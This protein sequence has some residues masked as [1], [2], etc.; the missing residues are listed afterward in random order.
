MSRL[1]LLTVAQHKNLCRVSE[2]LL[3]SSSGRQMTP[4]HS[5][6]PTLPVLLPAIGI[7]LL[8]IL[9][10]EWRTER[11]K[12]HFHHHHHHHLFPGRLLLL[13]DLAGSLSLQF[14]PLRCLLGLT[15][16]TILFQLLPFFLCLASLF[17][18]P[19]L[20]FFLK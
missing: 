5:T 3:P 13:I 12:C 18:S 8:L 4:E 1:A 7:L 17:L 10:V 9:P 14:V 15:V 20:F 2:C 16:F 11:V 6:H 19:L